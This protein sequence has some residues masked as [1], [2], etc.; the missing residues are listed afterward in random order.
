VIGIFLQEDERSEDVADELEVFC[1]DKKGV[2]T[3]R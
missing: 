3:F 2:E 1:V